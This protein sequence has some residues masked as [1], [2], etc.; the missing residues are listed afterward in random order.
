MFTIRKFEFDNDFKDFAAWCDYVTR[1]N[2][3]ASSQLLSNE[4][5]VIEN[6]TD[7]VVIGFLY[8]TN[9]PVALLEY[10]IA[11]PKVHRNDRKM[12][13][14]NL[15]THIETTAKN[16]GYEILMTFTSTIGFGDTLVR[17]GFTRTVKSYE[18]F[19]II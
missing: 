10:V 2:N 8:T 16:K 14:K 11:N 7:K 4:G 6:N 9:S 15:L 12:A 17:N 1:Q 19:K 13:I 5:Y 18:Y 3:S